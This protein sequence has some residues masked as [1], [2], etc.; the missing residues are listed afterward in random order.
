MLNIIFINQQAYKDTLV[1]KELLH[2][3]DKSVLLN[4]EW[5]CFTD[6]FDDI[7]LNIALDNMVYNINNLLHSKKFENII[8]GWSFEDVELINQLISHLDSEDA[9][10]TIFNLTDTTIENVTNYELLNKEYHKEYYTLQSTGQLVKMSYVDTTDCSA[11]KSAH[12]LSMII[13]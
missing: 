4:T 1:G 12:I 3:L 9:Q 13:Q 2:L 7:S 8:I 6:Y 11:F 10:I 5:G